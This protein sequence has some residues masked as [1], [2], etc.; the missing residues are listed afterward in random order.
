MNGTVVDIDGLSVKV[1]PID[2]EGSTDKAHLLE[3]TDGHKII[4]LSISYGRITDETIHSC[5]HE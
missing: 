5:K 1:I 2:L 3:I 4:T